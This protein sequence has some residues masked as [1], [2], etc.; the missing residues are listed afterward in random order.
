MCYAKGFVEWCMKYSRWKIFHY[1]H[2][3]GLNL[4]NLLQK[5]N[6]NLIWINS[7]SMNYWR[8]VLHTSHIMEYYWIYFFA[9]ILHIWMRSSYLIEKRKSE[10]KIRSAF[11]CPSWWVLALYRR[12]LN[13]SKSQ[14]LLQITYCIY[15]DQ[16]LIYIITGLIRNVS[17]C[18]HQV[19]LLSCNFSNY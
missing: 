11:C 16:S 17:S 12:N 5:F 3:I 7:L 6:D 1:F 19:E 13:L 9:A 18:Y 15:E 14:I 8:D 2:H 4:M 10:C